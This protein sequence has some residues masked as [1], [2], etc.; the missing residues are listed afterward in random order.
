MLIDGRGVP[1]GV[2]VSGANIHDI[3]LLQ[4][5]LNSK[6][7]RREIPTN[8][9]RQVLGAGRGL[10]EFYPEADWQ[11]CMVHW[12]G[13]VGSSV[14]KSKVKEVMAMLKAIHAQ[15]DRPAAEKKAADVVAKL[16]SLKLSK[17]AKC[18]EEGA[19]ETLSYMAY[20]REHSTRIRTNNPLERIMREIRRRPRVVGAFPDGNS[21]LMLVAARLR[22]VA[23]TRWGT[24]KHLDMSRLT[25]Q[26]RE[27]ASENCAKKNGNV[28][29]NKA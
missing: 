29:V 19:S 2:E 13:N 7:I 20:P 6:P 5:T 28:H 11:R 3:R 17:A 27:N 21:A 15:E 14:P 26:R 22:H 4:G 9:K 8:R 24:R 18:V 1:L 10:G 16:R 25:D 12:Y 23:G